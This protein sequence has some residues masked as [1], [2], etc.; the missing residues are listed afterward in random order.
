MTFGPDGHLYYTQNVSDNIVRRDGATGALIGE[1]VPH[2]SGGLG[3]SLGLSFGP[4]GNLYAGSRADASV[5]RFDGT[6]GAFIDAFVASGSGGL[7]EPGG[8]LFTEDLAPVPEPG[9][10]FL[11]SAGLAALIRSLRRSAPRR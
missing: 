8:I 6:T 3:S 7:V 2:Q 11:L 5:L 9:T 10:G 1:F 4:D